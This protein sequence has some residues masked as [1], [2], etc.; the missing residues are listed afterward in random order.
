MNLQKRSNVKFV[1]AKNVGKCLK[2]NKF[3]RANPV[4]PNSDIYEVVTRRSIT[5]DKIP[6]QE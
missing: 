4:A 5:N 2:T 3:M 1:P 6:V